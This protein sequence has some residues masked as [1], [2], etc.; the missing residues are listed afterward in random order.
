[1][2]GKRKAASALCLLVLAPILPLWFLRALAQATVDGL[3]W[4]TEGRAWCKPF[5]SCCDRIETA[6]GVDADSEYREWQARMR[7]SP[8]TSKKP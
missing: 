5:L 2:S 4:L 7:E 8:I 3:D 6:F 1:M